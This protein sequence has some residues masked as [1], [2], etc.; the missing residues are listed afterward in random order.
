MTEVGRD[1]ASSD[2]KQPWLTS[3]PNEEQLKTKWKWL[4]MGED[5]TQP[6]RQTDEVRKSDK[7]VLR[8]H[9]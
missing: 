1:V 7:L 3:D 8:P 6:G 2:R 5:V 9:A 4:S